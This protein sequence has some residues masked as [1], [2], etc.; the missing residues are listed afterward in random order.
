M[1]HPKLTE[2]LRKY[3]ATLRAGGGD[4][5]MPLLNYDGL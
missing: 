1:N 3:K 5:R 2:S 4:G